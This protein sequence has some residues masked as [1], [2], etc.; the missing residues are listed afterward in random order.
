MTTLSLGVPYITRDELIALQPKLD[1]SQFTHDVDAMILLASR[2]VDAHTHN[3]FGAQTYEEQHSWN[4]DSRRI[5]LQHWPVIDIARF[6][7]YVSRGEYA[8]IQPQYVFVNNTQRY[9]EVISTALIASLLA[10]II[11]L[12][13]AWPVVEV[14]YAAGGEG[15]FATSGAT[16]AQAV[17]AV[18]T[19][20]QVS[21]IAP[22][23]VG[24]VLRLDSE[25]LEVASV[26]V[27]P[28]ATLQ[29][30]ARGGFGSIAAAHLLNA[31]IQRLASR[32]PYRV[33]AATA[34][35]VAA[36]INDQARMAEGM[37]GVKQATIGSYT[38]TFAG[39]GVH[40]L[41]LPPAA[42]MLLGEYGIISLG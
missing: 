8:E 5:Y 13:L 12:A 17:D 42:E 25:W 14:D 26:A 18:S 16:L 4:A 22:F 41:T 19:T 21:G 24:N 23:A 40:Q 20:L 10:P 28:P 34:V 31:S 29:V 1:L 35:T 32:I 3:E 33:K 37:T 38:V 30:V 9:L 6:R 36:W 7:V 11:G 27:G 39:E 15:S 2:L